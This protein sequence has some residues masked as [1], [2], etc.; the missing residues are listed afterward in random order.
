MHML[1][2]PAGHVDCATTQEMTP[3]KVGLD[4]LGATFQEVLAKIGQ[5]GRGLAMFFDEIQMLY[6]E[7]FIA[8][9]PNPNYE[10]FVCIVRDIQKLGKTG[11]HAFGVISGLASN[12]RDR[13][14]VQD[15]LVK[16]GSYPNLNNGA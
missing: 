9:Q 1:L 2:E 16:E 5:E 7:Q 3:S 10:P 11:A 4:F 15:E 14:Y 8:N 6:V 12:T 13:A